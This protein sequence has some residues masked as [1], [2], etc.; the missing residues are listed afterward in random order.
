MTYAYCYA[1]RCYRYFMPISN[2]YEVSHSIVYTEFLLKKLYF[3]KKNTFEIVFMCNNLYE[4]IT[5]YNACMIYG[6]FPKYTISFNER[7]VW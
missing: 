6:I 5:G 2:S 3:Y 4:H 1:E 7:K